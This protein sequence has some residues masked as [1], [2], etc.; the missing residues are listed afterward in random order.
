MHSGQLSDPLNSWSQKI[1]EIS[2]KRRKTEADHA[3]I[4]RLEFLGGLYLHKGQPCIPGEMLEATLINAA[5]KMRR[6]MQ[7]KAGLLCDSMY[8]LKYEGPRKP[9]ALFKD[10]RFQL[11]NPVRVQQNKVM[12]TRPKFDEWEADIEIKFL[13]T[14]LNRKEVIEFVKIGGEQVGLGDW[15]PRFGRYKLANGAA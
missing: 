15:R 8:P 2:G 4:A 14:L 6:G 11:R 7:A 5:K 13:P 9:E 10:P 1:A 12:R 3:E